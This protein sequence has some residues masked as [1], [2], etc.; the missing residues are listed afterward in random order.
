MLMVTCR[1]MLGLRASRGLPKCVV[2]QIMGDWN[3]IP[4]G[5]VIDLVRRIEIRT[6]VLNEV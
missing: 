6:R 1:G 2:V 4:L 5:F 3:S